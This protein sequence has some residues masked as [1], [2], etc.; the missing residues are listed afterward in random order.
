MRE[1][2]GMVMV[3]HCMVDCQRF[4]ANVRVTERLCEYIRDRRLLPMAVIDSILKK[5][6]TQPFSEDTF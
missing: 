4:Y 1:R 2:L 3:L 5:T 6:K